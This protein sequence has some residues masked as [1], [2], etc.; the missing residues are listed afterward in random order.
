MQYTDSYLETTAGGRG[1]VV[2]N[3]EVLSG[4]RQAFNRPS[5]G[6]LQA[7]GRP[8]VTVNS[9][10]YLVQVLTDLYDYWTEVVGNIRKYWK[11]WARLAR[12]MGQEGASPW[13][14]GIF[15]KIGVQ[16]VI[17]FGSEKCV[18]TP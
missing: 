18:L 17:L 15:F 11:R 9:L 6:L 5:T 10:K 1:D 8:L 2:E 16:V 14:S 4:L 13:V 7:F 12:I 3:G